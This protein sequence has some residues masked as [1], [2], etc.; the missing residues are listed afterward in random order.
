MYPD[1]Q[2]KSKRTS[3]RGSAKLGVKL[4]HDFANRGSFKDT[5][6]FFIKPAVKIRQTLVIESHQVQDRGMKIP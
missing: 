2:G 5:R 6:E 1:L 3:S 4:R